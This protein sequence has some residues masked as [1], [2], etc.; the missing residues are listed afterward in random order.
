MNVLLKSASILAHRLW[1]EERQSVAYF[2]VLAYKAGAVH[3]KAYLQSSLPDLR[4]AVERLQSLLDELP[5]ESE[6][7]TAGIKGIMSDGLER[8]ESNVSA[9][10]K[11]EV[12]LQTTILLTRHKLG[13]YQLLLHYLQLL[14]EEYA[15]NVVQTLINEAEN[16][17]QRFIQLLDSDTFAEGI[18]V[19][20]VTSTTESA[21]L[22]AL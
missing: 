12:A 2:K 9:T 17:L 22:A 13:S 4:K 5:P 8:I 14:K 11:N 20:P 7:N 21:N 1:K 6:G 3:L 18:D 16:T 15:V 10:V 19:F